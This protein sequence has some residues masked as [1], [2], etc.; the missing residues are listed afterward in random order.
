MRSEGNLPRD[1]GSQCA[2]W[3]LWET[4]VANTYTKAYEVSEQH[5]PVE[6]CTG[7]WAPPTEAHTRKKTGIWK[8]SLSQRCR[9]TM[10]FPR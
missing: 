8:P 9:A 1:S 4:Q 10:S 3:Q 6:S 7:A 5:Q 2:Q